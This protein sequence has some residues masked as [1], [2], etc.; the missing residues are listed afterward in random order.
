MQ[1]VILAGGLGTR[2]REETEFRPKPM[3]EIGGRPVI[4]HIMKNLSTYGI[5]DFIIAGGYKCEMIKQYFIDYSLAVSDFTIELGKPS[6]IAVH[7]EV[8]ESIWSVTV[9][10]TGHDTMT[11]GRVLKASRYVRGNEFLLTYGD[12]LGD[13]DITKLIA[14]HHE[15]RAWATVTT[16]QPRSRFGE[17]EI[18][19]SGMVTSFTEK[20]KITGW[21][22]IGFMMM[23]KNALEYFDG[24]CVLETGPLPRLAKDGRLAAFKHEGFWEPMDTFRE[25]RELNAMWDAGSAPWKTW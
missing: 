8:D 10:D 4:W 21:V 15:H 22:N 11:G 9:T 25:A 1:A 17:L 6:S 5:T 18:D 2:M 13:V 19:S 16:Y 23:T 14:F 20:P 24:D 7:G 3:V 12:G